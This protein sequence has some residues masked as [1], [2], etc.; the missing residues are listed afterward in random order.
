MRA[1]HSDPTPIGV[2]IDDGEK[3]YYITGDTLYNEEIFKDIPED[4]YALFLPVNFGGRICG[5]IFLLYSIPEVCPETAENGV[6]IAGCQL[7][8]DQILNMLL[9]V[10]GTNG[11]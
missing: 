3:K 4:I 6:D 9:D 10:L 5:Q 8:P 11:F 2:I 1:E 7:L